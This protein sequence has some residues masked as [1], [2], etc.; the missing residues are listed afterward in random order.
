MG[1]LKSKKKMGV[2]T[3]KLDLDKLKDGSEGGAHGS[4]GIEFQAM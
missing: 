3:A 4:F 2:T 1:K